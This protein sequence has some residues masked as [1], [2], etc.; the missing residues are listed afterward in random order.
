[1]QDKFPGEDGRVQCKLRVFRK[2][3]FSSS[4]KVEINSEKT[5]STAPDD[6]CTRMALR[7]DLNQFGSSVRYFFHREG[8]SIASLS[9]PLRSAALAT[10]AGS[11]LFRLPFSSGSFQKGNALRQSISGELGFSSCI[12]WGTNNLSA[13]K[14]IILPLNSSVNFSLKYLSPGLIQLWTY[15]IHWVTEAEL[16]ADDKCL[17]LSVW[18]V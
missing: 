10:N 13:L 4:A 11:S 2:F 15:C 16:P 8:V 3:H 7:T 5:C 17:T 18:Q 14:A 1:M 9:E 12:L 6:G